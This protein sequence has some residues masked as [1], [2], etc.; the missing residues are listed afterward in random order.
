M[1]QL[2]LDPDDRPPGPPYDQQRDPLWW[3]FEHGRRLQSTPPD[4]DRR[5][6]RGCLIALVLAVVLWALIFATIFA[7]CSGP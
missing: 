3:E 5:P 1:A 2:P 4:P 7:T 6:A